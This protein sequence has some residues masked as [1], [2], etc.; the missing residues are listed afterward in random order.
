M[1]YF[2]Y[3]KEWSLK[4]KP[5]LQFF[6]P[7]AIGTAHCINVNMARCCRDDRPRSSVVYR[8]FPRGSL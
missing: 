7:M 1:N 6:V 5:L 3:K 8:F 4:V 2:I